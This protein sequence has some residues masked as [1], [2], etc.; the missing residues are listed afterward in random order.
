MT[1]LILFGAL[2]ALAA[3]MQVSHVYTLQEIIGAPNLTRLVTDV[4]AMPKFQMDPQ[5]LV[6][7]R[8]VEGNTASVK[9]VQGQRGL[10]RISRHGAPSR[11]RGQDGIAAQSITLLNAAEHQ[12]HDMTTLLNLQSTDSDTKQKMGMQEIARQTKSFG[13][14]F[15]NTRR[16]AVLCALSFGK[17]WFNEDGELLVT[18]TDAVVTVDFGVSADHK[19][20][21][22][23]LIS[24][25]WAIAGTD[26][27]GD[28]S[29][30]KRQS[31][32][33]TGQELAY[34]Y[35]G[36]DVPK[37]FAV[38]TEIGTEIAGSPMLSQAMFSQEI[39]DGFQSLKWRPV[40]DSFFV[41]EDGTVQEA[42]DADK[43]VFTPEVNTD[44]Y[45][46]IEGSNIVPSALSKLYDD[47]TG[48]VAGI[49]E[50]H[51]R[52]SYARIME[53]PVVLKQVA[54]DCMLP[55]LNNGDAIFI[56][57]VKF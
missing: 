33:D 13:R 42:F 38:N 23:A 49:K 47:A 41:D 17:L 40:G 6:V 27:R 30:L 19:D 7:T 29:S 16:A 43:I 39:P 8:K 34:A 36:K 52:Y 14:R 21:C 35:Y 53:D 32:Q 56:A 26:I 46:F 4:K 24:A 12:I 10:V 44:W 25:S 3:L 15:E 28:I 31:V 57:D 5:L 22:G 45:D 9:K 2:I 37:H 20:Q 48:A 1:P 51:G 54:G 11:L 18:S 50:A 55:M